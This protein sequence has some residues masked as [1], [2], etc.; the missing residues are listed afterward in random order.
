MS[1][2]NL[3]LKPEELLKSAKEAWD[4]SYSPFSR[5]KV[6]AAVRT[7]DGRVFSGCNIENSSFGATVCAERVAIWKAV[8]EGAKEI[9]EVAVITDAN[10][11]W[12][13]CGLCRQVI[14][15]FASDQA[16]I[17]RA[18]TAGAVITTAFSELYPEAFRPGHLL[19]K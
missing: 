5:K 16:L 6:G 8:S 13:P 3:T 4:R 15:E 9:A 12:P 14:A 10:P 19:E 7:K 18:N 17:H 1:Q 2:N 11:P